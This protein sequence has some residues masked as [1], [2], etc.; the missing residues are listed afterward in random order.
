[1]DRYSIKLNKPVPEAKPVRKAPVSNKEIS[2]R[3]MELSASEQVEIV[4]Q[5]MGYSASDRELLDQTFN[6][7][8]RPIER[9]ENMPMPVEETE[10]GSESIETE[11]AREATNELREI[12]RNRITEET[13]GQVFPDPVEASNDTMQMV[14]DRIVDQESIGDLVGTNEL[15]TTPGDKGEIQP[16]TQS[17]IQQATGHT[18]TT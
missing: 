1:M 14:L 4:Q 2:E 10:T 6:S 12:V 16:V 15:L 3:I 7:P 9:P 17:E 18:G 11:T 13:S 8:Q 5:L